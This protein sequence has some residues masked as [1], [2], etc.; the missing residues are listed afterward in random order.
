ME[1][2]YR[3]NRAESFEEFRDAVR[4]FDVP[5]QNFVYA[6]VDGNIG[7]QAPGR[8]PIR[9]GGT[10]RIPAPGWVDDYRWAGYVPFEELPYL[11]NPR[12]DY[13]VSANNQVAPDDYPHHL[14]SEFNHGYRARRI[15]EL[16]E[17]AGRD[18]D[19]EDVIAMHGDSYNIF[20]DVLLPH[21][22]DLE[23]GD[24]EYGGGDVHGRAIA[25]AREM[26]MTW[27]R[28]MTRDSAGAAL[29]ALF[30]QNL[31]EG[32]F[33]DQIPE[34]LW[35]GS[36]RI[37][38]GSRVLSVVEG[39]LGR[40][41]SGW[42][43]DVGTPAVREDRDDL[44]RRAL[45]AALAEGTRRFDDA[46]PA[47]WRW[48]EIHTA[49]FRNQSLGESGVGIIESI[50]NR[51]PVPVAGGMQQ[52]LSADWY[53]T[54]PYEVSLLSSM[55]QILDFAD[56]DASRMIHTTG[57]SGHPFHRHYDDMIE[58]WAAVEY[59]PHYFTREALSAADTRR[60]VL[61]PRR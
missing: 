32:I 28:R 14:A 39:L 2:V 15:V 1:S 18:V 57:Q 35:Q 8:I 7:Y 36:P 43:D 22:Q 17:D 27:D 13:V 48:G 29:Y 52:V 5:A 6:D 21:L 20:A 34:E 45:A 59:H 11:Y 26:L 9:R 46:E 33:T 41:D 30:Y 42:W 56:L 40:P 10:G 61:E 58:A 53:F 60:L 50:F 38:E 47:T 37:G 4:L 24:G 19:T 51:G 49:E 16:I 44:L 3:L 25:D 23:L 55:R 12:K 54:E 31:V